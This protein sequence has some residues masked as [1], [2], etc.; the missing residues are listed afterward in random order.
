[1]QAITA[2]VTFTHGTAVVLSTLASFV[3]IQNFK[4]SKLFVEPAAGNSHVCYLGDAALA[5]G[6]SSV[7][8]V[9]RQL[10]KP[11]AVDAILDSFD[12]DVTGGHNL[13]DLQQYSVDGT[14]AEKCRVTVYPG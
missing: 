5:L 1:M 12:L 3:G 8:H 13:I 14:T 9:I 4:V 7:D 6:T 2:T 10:A 11:T